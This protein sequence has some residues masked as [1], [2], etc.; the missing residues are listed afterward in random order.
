MGVV[1]ISQEVLFLITFMKIN[2]QNQ[3]ITTVNIQLNKVIVKY[4]RNQNNADVLNSNKATDTSTA[5]P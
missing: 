5:L 3:L 2:D 4:S 1:T